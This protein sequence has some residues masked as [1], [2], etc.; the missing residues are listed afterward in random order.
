MLLT[1]A[2]GALQDYNCRGLGRLAYILKFRYYTNDGQ[3]R[4]QVLG[5][6]RLYDKL[7][8]VPTH[9][10]PASLCAGKLDDLRISSQIREGMSLTN[11]PPG[12]RSISPE[13]WIAF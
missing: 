2:L 5:G 3:S 7:I 4:L 13:D 8:W 10:S 11:F 9:P 6:V 12:A 1:S